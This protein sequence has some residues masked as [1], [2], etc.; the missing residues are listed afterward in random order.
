MINFNNYDGLFKKKYISK[1]A[2]TMYFYHSDFFLFY[3]ESFDCVFMYT[4]Q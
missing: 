1:M 4:H 3:Y 2:E